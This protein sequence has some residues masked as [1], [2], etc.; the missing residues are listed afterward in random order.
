MN[1][2]D[3]EIYKIAQKISDIAWKI[4]GNIPQEFKFKTGQQFLTAADSIGA[5]IAEGYGRYH[6]KDSLRFYYFARGSLIETDWWT[7]LL[8]NRNL[9]DPIFREELI[10]LLLKEKIKLNKF[11]ASTSSKK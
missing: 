3:L 1:L 2:E 4:Y 10:N 8:I 9:I 11:I 5:N 7:N 6:Y